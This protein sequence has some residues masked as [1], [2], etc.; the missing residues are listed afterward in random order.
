MLGSQPSTVNCSQPLA[1]SLP[2]SISRPSSA[3]IT[4]TPQVIISSCAPK[5]RY[6]FTYTWSITPPIN[7]ILNKPILTIPAFGFINL[8]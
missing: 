7:V 8:I 3:G 4:I 5:I 2:T 6:N 1:V